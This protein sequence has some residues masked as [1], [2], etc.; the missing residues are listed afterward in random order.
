[1]TSVMTVLQAIRQLGLTPVLLNGVYRL[2][3]HSGF[4]NKV[5]NTPGE[6]SPNAF[7]MADI[8]TFPDIDQLQ[9]KLG[10]AGQDELLCQAKEIVAGRVRL[11]G[12]QPQALNL[13]PAGELQNWTA[14][15]LGKAQV[16]A[17]HGDIKFVW[18]PCRFGWAI[19]L[20]RAYHLTQDERYP[21]AFW[22]YFETFIQHNPP[23]QGPNW[24]SAQ[25][26]GLRLI[27]MAFAGQVMAVSD[28]STPQRK[29]QLAQA[30][31]QHARRIP[32]TLLYARAQNN[33]HLLSEAA[34]LFTASLVLPDHR[35]AP[36][37]RRLG[38]KWF[39]R[40]IQKQISPD[41]VYMQ[42]S[43]NYHR[44]MLQL[45][46]WMDAICRRRG[47]VLPAETQEK[48][49]AAT[50]WLLVLLDPVSGRTPNLGA[51]DGAYILPLSTQSFDDYRPVAQAAGAAF[52]HKFPVQQG[53]WDEMRLWLG[54]NASGAERMGT[55][56]DSAELAALER[57]IGVVRHP[58][59][60]HS[61]AYLRLAAFQDRPGHADL[62]HVD[63]WYAGKNL[64]LDAGTYLYN[65]SPPWDNALTRTQVHNTVQ[66]DEQEQMRR[67]GRFLYLDWVN[68]EIVSDEQ[69]QDG[70]LRKLV[71]QH[72]GYARLGVI[73]RRFLSALEDGNWLVEDQLLEKNGSYRSGDNQRSFCL[74]WL[75]PD[76]PWWL[77]RRADEVDLH[78][79]TI[80]GRIKIGLA[81]KAGSP[82]P[83]ALQVQVI[84]AGE[85]LEG[86]GLISPTW[87]WYSPLY[88]DK[89]PALALRCLLDSQLPVTITS[90]WIFNEG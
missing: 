28:Q 79:D 46:L 53:A 26:V 86:D 9:E 70:R 19:T 55:K 21:S 51:N 5:G 16:Q 36:R 60:S 24:V 42:H 25:E 40:G 39:Q 43:T 89:I 80:S 49:A 59:N 50:R 83:T 67:V 76:C 22:T 1:M 54:L 52:L 41:G 7:T 62:L 8:L 4:Y 29:L 56:D 32:P 68:T 81:R 71:A 38:W 30:I 17:P 85:L 2:A 12:G 65:A 88:G 75:L 87:G 44:L 72:G 48:L 74:H 31:A 64:A 58:Q 35:H 3:L 84:R 47:L 11:F 27:A 23:F 66:V 20:A 13:V 34:G 78:L 69:A 61:W 82:S 10:K 57:K 77:E 45:A 90:R 6:E 63:L 15:E 14:Y 18:E 33:N 73:H 37:W